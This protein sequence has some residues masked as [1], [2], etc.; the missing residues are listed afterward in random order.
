MPAHLLDGQS[1]CRKYI[2]LPI[3][4]FR[5]GRCNQLALGVL[6]YSLLNRRGAVT[7]PLHHILSLQTWLCNR[8]R[9]FFK[10]DL[11]VIVHFYSD[12]ITVCKF[13]GE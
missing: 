4:G 1:G 9:R 5:A 10:S 3:R 8:F 13:A 2:F 6:A 12:V 11:A 7:A